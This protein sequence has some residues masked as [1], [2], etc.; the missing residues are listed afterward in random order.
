MFTSYRTFGGEVITTIGMGATGVAIAAAV[1]CS[2][3]S[4]TAATP[5]LGRAALTRPIAV[6]DHRSWDLGVIESGQELRHTFI[7]RNAGQTPLTLARGPKL[8]ACTITDLPAEPVPPGGQAE[9]TMRFTE[10][11]KSDT[12]KPGRFSKGVRVLTNDPENPDLLLEITATVNRRVSVAPSPLTLL[13]DSSKPVSPR[14]RSAETLVYSERWQR[15]ELSAVEASRKDLSW[16]T[17]PA[18]EAELKELKATGGCRIFVTLPPDMAEGRFVEWI[19]FAAVPSAALGDAPPRHRSTPPEPACCFRLEIRGRVAGRLEFFG[20]KIV[21]SNVLRLGSLRQGEPV[22]D[23]VLMKIN[24]PCRRLCVARIETDPAFLRARLAPYAS[25]SK[26]SGLYRIEVEIP[27]DAPS[28]AFLVGHCGVIRLRTDH[29]RL[30]RSS[31][32]SIFPWLAHFLP[33]IDQTLFAQTLSP[34]TRVR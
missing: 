21:G 32:E 18:K 15:F 17:E 30:R 19:D 22:R 11:A 2:S 6:V 14:Q 10:S 23:I 9:V 29:P 16:R 4:K 12:L 8:C 33:R 20:P 28:C 13:I 25:G 24:D 34:D 26:Q 5:P 27:A 1:L 3:Q 31:C 7:I